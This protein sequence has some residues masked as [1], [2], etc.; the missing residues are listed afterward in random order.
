MFAMNDRIT[1]RQ[2]YYQIIMSMAGIVLV[3]LPGYQNLYGMNGIWICAVSGILWGIY[4]F[5]LVRISS[6]YERLE[7]LLGVKGTKIYGIVMLSFFLTTGSFL[8]SV[9]CE[10]VKS[11]FGIQMSSIILNLFILG[12]CVLSGFPQIQ[13]RGRMAEISF[14]ILGSVVLI[15][16][17]IS[18][19]NQI[20]QSSTFFVYLKQGMNVHLKPIISGGYV[21]FAMFTGLFGLPFLLPHVKG[22]RWKAIAG[23]YGT[24][25]ILLAAVCVLLQGSY[26][27]AQ[28][29]RRSWPMLSLFGGIRIP[30]GFVFRLDPI[31]IGILVLFLLFSAGSAL[32]YG[33]L[34]VKKTQVYWKWYWS[35][36]VVYSLAL[37]PTGYGTILQYYDK[38]L[39]FVYCPFMVVSH[40]VIWVRG[41]SVSSHKKKT[42]NEVMDA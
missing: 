26:G 2:L 37:L 38:L 31:W 42:R 40:L 15:F 23:A 39:L 29:V 3:I 24:L 17:F 28:A 18:Y 41:R 9:I 6:Y 1:A 4:S 30:G 13:R 22:N 11:Y 16:L 10:I 20:L 35:L 12:S 19:G 36:A 33:N 14:S 7:Q 21:L 8:I 25:L 34:I 5:I 27:I 32:F